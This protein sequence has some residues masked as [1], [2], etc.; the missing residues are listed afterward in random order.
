MMKILKKGKHTVSYIELIYLLDL[1]D[2]Q[3]D[4]GISYLNDMLNYDE[5]NIY[6]SDVKKGFE[7]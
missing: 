5:L 4:E 7:I 1:A 6:I 2:K 3:N